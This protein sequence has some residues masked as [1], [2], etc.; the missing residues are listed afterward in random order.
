M[1]SQWVFKLV[2]MRDLLWYFFLSQIKKRVLNLLMNDES[3]YP[4]RFAGGVGQYNKDNGSKV[5]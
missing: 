1:D 2:G 3:D 4:Q 5:F